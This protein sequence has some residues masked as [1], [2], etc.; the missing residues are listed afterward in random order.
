M[1]VTYPKIRWDS[2]NNSNNKNYCLHNLI[3]YSNCKKEYLEEIMNLETAL[4][5]WL[6]FLKV[7]TPDVIEIINFHT[8]LSKQLIIARSEGRDEYVAPTYLR[9]NWQIL[10]EIRPQFGFD[11]DFDD[12]V[13]DNTHDFLG[14]RK[15]Y[16]EEQL[17]MIETQFINVQKQLAGDEEE[18]ENQTPIVL[19][20]QL[21]KMQRFAFDLI[22]EKQNKK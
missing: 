16:T 2:E 4:E 1:V 13:A 22:K 5:R 11:E 7:A 19:P 8:D 10:S 20:D 15:N 18:N 12:I 21:N 17:Q 6:E 3:K 9:D 14:H